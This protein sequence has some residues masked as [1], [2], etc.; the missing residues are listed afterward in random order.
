M[1]K[2]ERFFLVT[3][4]FSFQKYAIITSFLHFFKLEF[5]SLISGQFM[6]SFSLINAHTNMY[7]FMYIFVHVCVSK[8]RYIPKYNLFNL[9]NATCMYVLW[10][11]HL[12]FGNQFVCSSMENKML[13]SLSVPC[14]PAVLCK[15][16]NLRYSLSTMACQLAT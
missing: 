10:A 5:P 7:V 2:Y 11:D 9:Y 14:L 13:P 16:E 1:M 3:F 12:V 8:Y 4:I 6:L 15:V